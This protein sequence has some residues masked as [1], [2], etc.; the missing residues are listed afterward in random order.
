MFGGTMI[1]S[2][3][4]NARL[5]TALSVLC[6]SEYKTLMLENWKHSTSDA[7]L[8]SNRPLA[9]FLS[10]FSKKSLLLSQ[11]NNVSLSISSRHPKT[12][13]NELPRLSPF[14]FWLPPL[15]SI[16]PE[17]CRLYPNLCSPV[18]SLLLHAFNYI[19]TWSSYTTNLKCSHA[20]LNLSTLL[21]L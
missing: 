20:C 9:Y 15:P 4:Q 3:L 14:L 19:N 8:M 18:Q 11:I 6:L 12:F 21:L 2:A 10:L 16:L 13:Q 17:L 7:Q 5:Q 1:N